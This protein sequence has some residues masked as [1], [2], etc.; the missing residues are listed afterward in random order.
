[1]LVTL[2]TQRVKQQY[3]HHLHCSPIKQY[4]KSSTAPFF[5]A[6]VQVLFRCWRH[7]AFVEEV[8][9][10]LS[11]AGHCCHEIALFLFVKIAWLESCQAVQMSY[12]RH[13]NFNCQNK[14]N[15]FT[16]ETGHTSFNYLQ[17]HSTKCKM[18][19][20]NNLKCVLF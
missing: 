9:L 8:S 12:L 19:C 16:F 17:A 3:L 14:G 18:K 1:M 2:G 13:V 15:A 7:F 20:L 11:E 5:F 4:L 10:F 6:F